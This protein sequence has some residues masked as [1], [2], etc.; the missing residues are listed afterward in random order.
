PDGSALVLVRDVPALGYVRL[1]ETDRP[2]L[3]PTDEGATPEAA[4]GGFHLALDPTS[5]AIRSLTG[6]D[7]KERVNPTTWSGLNQLVYARGGRGSALWTDAPVAGLGAPTDLN[8]AQSR[9]VAAR[10]ERL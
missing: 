2:A 3:P 1:D 10:R 9:L 7:G 6:P 8:L 5:G 4:A